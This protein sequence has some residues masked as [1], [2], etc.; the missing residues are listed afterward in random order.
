[1]SCF[2][3]PAPSRS[4]GPRIT[5]RTTPTNRRRGQAEVDCPGSSVLQVLVVTVPFLQPFFQVA[6]VTFAWESWMIALLALMPFTVIE[7]TTLVRAGLGRGR[8]ER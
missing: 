8:R 1:M 3:R 6:P 7:L 5:T 4:L 2:T